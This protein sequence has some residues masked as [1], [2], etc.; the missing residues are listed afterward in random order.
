MAEANLKIG[1]FAICNQRPSWRLRG[2]SRLAVP[3][4]TP[5]RLNGETHGAPETSNFAILLADFCALLDIDVS[6]GFP[7]T[8]RRR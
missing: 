5:F 1:I 8:D 4:A 2:P 6:T 7:R 3:A